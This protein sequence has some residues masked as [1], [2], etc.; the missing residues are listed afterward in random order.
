[1]R[2]RFGFT[3]VMLITGILGLGGITTGPW[4]A[5]RLHDFFTEKAFNTAEGN[6]TVKTV[7]PS[8]PISRP[9]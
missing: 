3:E 7:R 1:M 8:A 5:E 6:K 2:K 9:T 4:I